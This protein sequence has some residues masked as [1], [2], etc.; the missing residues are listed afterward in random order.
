MS[1]QRPKQTSRSVLFF[2]EEPFDNLAAKGLMCTR[3]AQYQANGE[4]FVI[5]RIE[6]AAPG[7]REFLSR[8]K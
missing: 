4:T 7:F 1:F 5:M 8:S 2:S 6:W 3:V